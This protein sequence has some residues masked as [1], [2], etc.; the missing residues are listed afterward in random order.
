MDSEN[1]SSE[2]VG[3]DFGVGVQTIRN[4]RSAGIPKRRVEFVRLK[5][6]E[7]SAQKRE[8]AEQTL[9]LELTNEQFDQWNQAALAEGLIIRDWAIKGLDELAKQERLLDLGEKSSIKYQLPKSKSSVLN[10][11][12]DVVVRNLQNRSSAFVSV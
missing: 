11:A 8:L 7:F 3:K 4:W 1:I 6:F 5:I 2:A 9:V 12:S 10:D